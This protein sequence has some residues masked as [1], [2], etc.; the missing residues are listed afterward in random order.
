MEAMLAKEATAK[1]H[2]DE[3]GRVELNK[4]ITL[5]ATPCDDFTS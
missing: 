3:A 1:A 2:S 4:I 5:R